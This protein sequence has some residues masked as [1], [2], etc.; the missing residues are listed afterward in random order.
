MNHTYQ[1]ESKTT[2]REVKYHCEYCKRDGHHAEFCF[3]RK[4]DER[5]ECEL[6]NR[7]MYHPSHGVHVPPIQRH[8]A[9]PRGAMPQGAR[10][11]AMRPRDGRARRSSGRGQY[12]FGF[13][14]G[15]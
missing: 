14:G 1:S 8:S 6:K 3:R 4:R 11:Q 7:D 9:I 10:S 13:H 5:Q 2:K 12:D 15:F